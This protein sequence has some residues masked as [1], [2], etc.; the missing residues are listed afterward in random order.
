MGDYKNHISAR[1]PRT[2]EVKLLLAQGAPVRAILRSPSSWAMAGKS[3][4]C[5]EDRGLGAS[6]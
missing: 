5:G 1:V 2:A 6:I 4:S 3:F